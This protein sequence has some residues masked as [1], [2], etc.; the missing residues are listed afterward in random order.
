[1]ATV[2]LWVAPLDVPPP[3]LARLLAGLSPAERRRAERYRFADDARRFA[4]GRGWLR[5]V[6][7]AELHV[8]PED[9]ELADGPGK[10]RLACTGGPFFNLSRSGDLV[11]VALGPSEVGVDVEHHDGG[12]ALE[13]ATLACTPA[14]RADLDRLPAAARAEAFLWLWTAKEAYL[15]ARG[16]GLDVSP[17]RVELG[18]GS[19][20]AAAPVRTVGEARPGR[21]WVRRLRP[22]P[23]YVAAVA[24]EGSDWLVDVRRPADVLRED[25]IPGE[26]IRG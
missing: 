10:P 2:Q 19:P 25:V 12:R 17:D 4:A 14:E 26:V 9:V 16:I 8:Q 13:A 1:M 18:E 6:L 3:V 7:G 11:L 20:G 24:A 5:H 15:K 23:G 21:W 22:R